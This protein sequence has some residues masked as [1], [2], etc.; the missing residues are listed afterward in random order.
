MFNILSVHIHSIKWLSCVFF[1]EHKKKMT[2]RSFDYEKQLDCI[3]KSSFFTNLLL[4]MKL[5][6]DVGTMPLI[7]YQFW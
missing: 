2:Q 6:I 4:W 3:L 5:L 7:N 1:K